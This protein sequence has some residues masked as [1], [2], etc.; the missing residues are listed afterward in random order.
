[1]LKLILK[2]DKKFDFTFFI[3]PLFGQNYQLFND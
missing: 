1:M 3:K 2:H